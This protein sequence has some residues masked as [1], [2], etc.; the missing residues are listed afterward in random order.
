M[1]HS[2]EWYA[3]RASAT[4]EQKCTAAKLAAAGKYAACRATVDKK[5]ELTAEVAD[6]TK[7]DAKQLAAWTK[8]ED[9]YGA[10]CVTS[11]DQQA[12]KAEL[13]ATTQCLLDTLDP[14]GVKPSIEVGCV[15]CPADGVVV[16]DTCWI[17]GAAGDTCTAACALRDMDYDAKTDS[18]A[19]STTGAGHPR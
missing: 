16:D 2:T 1:S 12:V 10:G 15:P 6:Y 3:G 18:Y 9:K 5:A 19:G 7:C 4:D 17:L 13:I 11:G 8:I 14:A